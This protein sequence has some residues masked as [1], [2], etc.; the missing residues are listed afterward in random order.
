MAM[1][2]LTCLVIAVLLAGCTYPAHLYCDIIRAP[3]LRT[4]LDQETSIEQFKTWIAHTYG[5]ASDSVFATHSK[6]REYWDVQWQ[7]SGRIYD[8]ALHNGRL[9]DRAGMSF[10][11]QK[12]SADQVIA[13]LGTPRLYYAH[14]NWD[15]GKYALHLYLLFPD[16]GILASGARYFYPKPEQTP[17]IEGSFRI[18][19]FT[20]VRPGPAEQLLQKIYIEDSVSMDPSIPAY[21]PWPGNWQDIVVEIN[22][23]IHW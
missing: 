19:R 4:Q 16:Q 20:F 5:V 23:N 8:L 17:V 21:R 11:R 18:S 9:D 6:E 15:L 14:Y 13:C 12:P 2:A 3:A 10:L 22:P 1:R 7:V